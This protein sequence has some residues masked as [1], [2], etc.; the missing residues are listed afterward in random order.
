MSLSFTGRNSATNLS[1]TLTVQ[2]ADAPPKDRLD[3]VY[4]R[5]YTI[6]SPLWNDRAKSLDHRLDSP[7]H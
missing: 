2:V 6:D 7:L 4:T 5:N 3:V 1:S